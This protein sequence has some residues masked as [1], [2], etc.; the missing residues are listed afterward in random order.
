M[1]RLIPLALVVALLAGCMGGPPIRSV[2]NDPEEMA[3]RRASVDAEIARRTASLE[4][5]R[6]AQREAEA[7]R[8]V[9]SPAEPTRPAAAAGWRRPSGMSMGDCRRMATRA[10]L[11]RGA[12]N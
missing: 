1:T 12:C 9:Y 11:D 6:A 4:R 10:D 8:P 3:R 7:R 5:H 2:A